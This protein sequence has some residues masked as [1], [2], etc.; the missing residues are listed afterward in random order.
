ME[1]SNTSYAESKLPGRNPEK[2]S[3]SSPGTV[4][5][6]LWNFMQQFEIKSGGTKEE[7]FARDCMGTRLMMQF[8]EKLQHDSKSKNE[9]AIIPLMRY[10]LYQYVIAV[11]HFK[12]ELFICENHIRGV[13]SELAAVESLG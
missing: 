7:V 13:E 3:I 8:L 5:S 10:R 4:P 11:N 9:T 2:I 1:V 12:D 6:L